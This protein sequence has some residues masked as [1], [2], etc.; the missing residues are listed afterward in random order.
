ML[1]QNK[2]TTLN[3]EFIDKLSFPVYRS[4]KEDGFLGLVSFDRHTD[5]PF[6]TSKGG[7]SMH[8]EYLK[9][10]IHDS[11]HNENNVNRF[12][13]FIKK[14]KNVTFLFEC[15]HDKDM[16]H[17]VD[18]E[19]N[20]V[21]LI[22][23]LNNTY[24]DNNFNQQ[25]LDEMKE[26]FNFKTPEIK[27]LKDKDE[28][29]SSLTN[30]PLIKNIEGYVYRDSNGYMF[31]QKTTWFEVWKE[32]R[33]VLSGF[34]KC[35]TLFNS[36]SL[37]TKE[38]KYIQ[39]RKIITDLASDPNFDLI[40]FINNECSNSLDIKKLRHKYNKKLSGGYYD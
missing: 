39:T 23:A 40:T 37:D 8:G 3:N 25:A 14:Y 18:Y 19:K 9:N 30:T 32:V 29:L 36:E 35:P 7:S 10:T 6:Y 24:E 2:E 17:I 21:V 20:G 22:S 13:D 5:A 16:P 26:V 28:L 4:L 27:I 11:L 34:A 38:F 15:I 1:N 12:N 33:K 31:K